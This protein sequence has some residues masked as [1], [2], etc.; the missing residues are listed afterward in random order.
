MLQ[1]NTI[2]KIGLLVSI[3]C[4]CTML[5]CN[6]QSVGF[7]DSI[8]NKETCRKVAM[9]DSNFKYYISGINIEGN[10]KTKDYIIIG[11][12]KFKVGDSIKASLFYEKIQ[13]SRELIYNTNLFSVVEIKPIAINSI[14]LN[15]KISVIEKWYIYPEPEFSI[16]D[17]NFNEWYNTYHADL[18]RATYGINFSHMNFTGRSDK[19]TIYLLNGYTRNI[20]ISYNSPYSNKKLDRGFQIETGYSQT[21]GFA[22]KTNYENHLMTYINNNFNQEN[23]SF[24]ATYRIRK[25]YYKRNIFT[26]KANYLRV[27]DSINTIAYNPYF[28]Q[29][30]KGDVFFPDFS[31]THQYINVDNINYPSRGKSYS[32]SILKRGLGFDG[33]LNMLK[34]N[35]IYRKYFDLG[36]NFNSSIQLI[37]DIKFPF[38][39]SYINQ[40]AL[41]YGNYYL[42][43]LEYYVIDG[44]SSGLS[45]MTLRK[46]IYDHHFHLPFNIRE[47]PFF[48]VAIYLKSYFDAGYSLNDKEFETRLNNR[49]L[50]TGGF[51]IDV[52]T[53]YDFSFSI[54]FSLNQ[55]GEKGVF[56]Q[57]G[58]ILH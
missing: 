49:V 2:K 36:H 19:L 41:G 18:N 22:Y 13:R 50:Y 10:R 44:Y 40:K 46:K 3:L 8:I 7:K 38:K 35:L 56:L 53:L 26:I 28:L 43:G 17:R 24:N 31:Y 14:D 47:L 30:E 45:R 57:T 25:G 34:L 48:P 6:G 52:L 27:P 5:F 58:T 15:I 21:K 37:T 11:E 16:I 42:R 4:F 23:Y 9:I 55:L 20:S 1:N 39:Q 51:G 54:E 32:M 12:M 33:N 29:S